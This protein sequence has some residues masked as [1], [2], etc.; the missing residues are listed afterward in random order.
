MTQ[1]LVD[2]PARLELLFSPRGIAIVGASADAARIGGQPLH[3]L[4]EFGYRGGIYPVNPKYGEMSGLACYPDVARVPRPCDVALI[5]LSAQHVPQ[6]I[7]DCGKAGIGFA[8]VLSAGFS[9]AGGEGKALQEALHTAARKAGVRVVGPNC[10]GVVN[11]KDDIRIGFGPSLRVRTL[12]RGPIA[13]VTQSGGVG[14]GLVAITADAG[15]GYHYAVSTGNEADLNALDFIE[16][17]LERDDVEI[18]TCFL[19]GVTDGRR[20]VR[21]GARALELRKPILVWKVGNTP[22]GRQA[23]ISHT[24]RMTASYDLFRT[25]FSQGGF[26]EISDVDD[27]VDCAKVFLPRTY[28]AGSGVGVVSVSGGAAV[29]FADQCLQQGLTLPPFS[30]GTAAAVRKNLASSVTVANPLDATS[31]ALI[32]GLTAYLEVI[33]AV[34]ADPKVDQVIA[35]APRARDSLAWGAQFIELVRASK[36]PVIVNWPTS[37]EDH[38]ELLKLLEQHGVPCFLAPGRAVRALARLT[39]FAAKTRKS[40]TA[41][42]GRAMRVV[43][44]QAIEFPGGACTLGEHDAKRVLAAYGIPVVREVLITETGLSALEAAPLPFPLAIKVD[45]PDLPH[46]TEAGAVWLG[47]ADFAVFKDAAREVL[48]AARAFKPDARINGVLVQEMASGLEVIVGAVNDPYFGPTV[49]FGLGGVFAE[50]LHDVSRRFAPFDAGTAREMIAEIKA[51]PLLTGYRG[52]APL[53]IEAL[54]ETLARVSQLVC[55]HAD[56]IQ[57]ID[58]N[59]VFV[60]AAGQ[61]VRAADALIVLKESND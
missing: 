56:R 28:P 16:Y 12:R 15:V 35:R 18:V 36:K 40:A 37:V 43:E 48:S 60:G 14:L 31:K 54:A 26:V 11:L 33:G 58:I 29:L 2:K 38:G 44:K 5:A 4:R 46:K 3:I 22:A 55:D 49:T 52:R 32:D 7:A 23:A 53:D 50:L 9:E 57:E 21:L 24:A 8:I 10:L 19:E 13:M 6:A 59:P 47:I 51:A 27:I 25:A 30:E 39:E 42:A 1:A 61:S 45:S 41:S 34:L 20:L 17:F